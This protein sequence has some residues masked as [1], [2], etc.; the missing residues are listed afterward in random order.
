MSANSPPV[1]WEEILSRPNQQQTKSLIIFKEAAFCGEAI[2]TYLASWR[3]FQSVSIAHDLEELWSQLCKTSEP[4]IML[5]ENYHKWSIE[6]LITLI[7]TWDASSGIIVCITK[8]TLAPLADAKKGN[9]DGIINLDDPLEEINKGF[10]NVIEG[11]TYYSKSI[12]H[13]THTSHTGRTKKKD[14]NGLTPRQQ[15]VL[16]KLAE[17]HTVRE[18]AEMMQLSAKAVDSHKYRIMKKLNL[19][20]KVRLARFAIREGMIDP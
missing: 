11:H 18:I 6:E 9:P 14:H 3:L 19:N 7:R 5:T 1:T 10:L 17:G 20:D 8:D 15:E 12:E 16:C 13:R 2:R 4:I